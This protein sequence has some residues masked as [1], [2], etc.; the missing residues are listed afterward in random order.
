MKHC[1]ELP[2]LLYVKKFHL[3]YRVLKL[4]CPEIVS[5]MKQFVQHMLIYT[6]ENKKDQ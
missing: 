4:H 6:D 5:K 1:N 2:A 3:A